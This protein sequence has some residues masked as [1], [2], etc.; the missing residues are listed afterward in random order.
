MI[1]SISYWANA[2]KTKLIQ[3]H[4]QRNRNILTTLEIPELPYFTK[5]ATKWTRIDLQL[6][7]IPIWNP[8]KK[9]YKRKDAGANKDVQKTS[10]K[11]SKFNPPI[12]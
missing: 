6:S 11:I 3:F 9:G 5:M 7:I 10:W 12:V 4:F 2:L 8:E 1:T